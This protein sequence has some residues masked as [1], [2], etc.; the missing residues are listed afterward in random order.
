MGKRFV[1]T[2]RENAGLFDLR[3][4]ENPDKGCKDLRLF[5][6]IKCLFLSSKE[7]IDKGTCR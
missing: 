1:E 4:N 3:V 6:V 2:N 5:G 7:N